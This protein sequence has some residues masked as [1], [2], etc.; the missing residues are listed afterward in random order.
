MRWFVWSLIDQVWLAGEE[1][2]VRN[3]GD[4]DRFP[5]TNIINVEASLGNPERITLIL[6]EPCRFGREIL[7]IP[8][9]RW[10]PLSRHPLADELIRRINKLPAP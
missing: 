5:V 2:I 6:R 8:P 9:T 7:F 1:L 10:W 4:E 3:R